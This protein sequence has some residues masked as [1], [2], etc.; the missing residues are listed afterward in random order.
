MYLALVW[1]QEFKG[2]DT[3][4]TLTRNYRYDRCCEFALPERGHFTI[5][6]QPKYGDTSNYSPAT[7][8]CRDKGFALRLNA[9]YMIKPVCVARLLVRFWTLIKKSVIEISKS[10]RKQMQQIHAI[11]VYVMETDCFIL[12]Y[13]QDV[14]AL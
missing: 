9:D 8:G 11:F 7:P 12:F 3:R 10:G 2:Y 14:Y 6:T 13:T 5:R 1:F 4:S